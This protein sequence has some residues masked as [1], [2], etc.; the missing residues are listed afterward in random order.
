MCRQGNSFNIFVKDKRQVELICL[1][2]TYLNIEL[3]IDL[4]VSF[5]TCQNGLR[6]SQYSKGLRDLNR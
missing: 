4:A 1:I 2:L 3:R 5:F 6:C